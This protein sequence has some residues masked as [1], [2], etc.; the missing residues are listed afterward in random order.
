MLEWDPTC[1]TNK[2]THV[3]QGESVAAIL[4][5]IAPLWF[6]ESPWNETGFSAWANGFGDFG[7]ERWEVSER[8]SLDDLWPSFWDTLW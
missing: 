5:R 4:G 2:K 1:K 7:C 8:W 6:V 3:D